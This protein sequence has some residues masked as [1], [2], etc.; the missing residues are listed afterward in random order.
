M[1]QQPFLPSRRLLICSFASLAGQHFLT[2][3]ATEVLSFFSPESETAFF[4]SGLSNCSS[5]LPMLL[6]EVC[7]SCAFSVPWSFDSDTSASSTLLFV[8][9]SKRATITEESGGEVLSGELEPS[10][11]LRGV[12]GNSDKC[13][14]S[15]CIRGGFS[16]ISESFTGLQ[17]SLA[18]SP[19][20]L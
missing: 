14:N 5:A 11:I 12:G 13:A 3:S 1:A 17:Q 19:P 9:W 8:S 18:Y 6:V 7:T 2:V 15:F 20:N 16:V 10:E 4:K